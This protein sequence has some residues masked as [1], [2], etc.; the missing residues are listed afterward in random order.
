[1]FLP[2]IEKRKGNAGHRFFASGAKDEIARGQQTS[3]GFL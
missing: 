1:L 2:F 3:A